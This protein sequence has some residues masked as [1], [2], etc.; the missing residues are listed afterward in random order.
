MNLTEAELQRWLHLRSIEWANWPAFLSQPVLPILLI[1]FR[2]PFVL[3]GLV[4]IDIL[5]AALRYSFTS[6]ALSN[7]GCVLVVWL[8]WP[9]AVGSGLYL[10]FVTR[11]YGLGILA[12]AWPILA[13]LVCV[14]GKV[15]RIELA[16]AKNVG[17]VH[18][19]TGL[20]I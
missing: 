10:F 18:E 11:S 5:W 9:A 17:Y 1:F 8:K 20:T 13:G 3:G 15:G 6:P 19:D 12:L 2:W 14:P 16:L 7:A 4:A